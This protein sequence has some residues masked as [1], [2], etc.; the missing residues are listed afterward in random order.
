[1]GTDMKTHKNIFLRALVISSVMMLTALSSAHAVTMNYQGGWLATTTY[2]AGAVVVLNKQTYYAL[3]GANVNKNPV[4]FPAYWQPLGT[5]VPTTYKIGSRGPGGGWIF[6]VDLY[7][8]YPG[9]TYLEAAPTDIAPPVAWCNNA[10]TS[11]PAAGGWA[12]KGVGKGKT[13]TA[14]MLAVCSSGAANAA[15][16]YLTA[17]KSDWFLP[18]LGELMLMYTNLLQAGVGGF[19]YDGYWSSTEVVS[20]MAWFQDFNYGWQYTDGKSYGY[21]LGVRAVRAF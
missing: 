20:S 17:T 16:Q 9:F 2:T 15:D 11:I 21:T 7:D 19:A 4:A 13:N 5:F 10:S 18:S 6:F 12:G 3:L 8:Q 1:M 14:A